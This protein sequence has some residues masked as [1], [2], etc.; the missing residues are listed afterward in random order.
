MLL[1][2]TILPDNPKGNRNAIGHGAPK[3]SRN[4]L[5]PRLWTDALRIAVHVG[6]RT[7]RGRKKLQAIADR[8]VEMALDGDIAA[9][10]EIGDRLEGKVHTTDEAGVTTITLNFRRSRELP[11]QFIEGEVEHIAGK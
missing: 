8:C 7:D 10:K 2:P 5:K 6:V 11:S 1:D 3:G 9:I 4:N